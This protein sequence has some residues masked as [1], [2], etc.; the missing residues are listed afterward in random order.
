MSP[1]ALRQTLAALA[2]LGAFTS[3]A[4][5]AHAAPSAKLDPSLAAMLGTFEKA[6][7]AHNAPAM[8]A[9]WTPDAFYN[10]TVANVQVKGRDAIGAAYA[11]LFKQQ[12]T[13]SLKLTIT[14]SKIEGG[15]ASLLGMAEVTQQGQL[16]TRSLFRASLE[17]VGASWL[18]SSVEESE[19]PA[20]SPTGMSQFGW[21]AGTWTEALPSGDVK[22]TYHWVNG[23][24]F[25]VR[26]YSRAAK[27][28]PAAEG[29]QI[30]GWDAEQQCIRTWLFDSNG[31][32]GEGYW[33]RQGA[34]KWVNKMA[35]KLPD[36]RRGSVTQIMTRKGD[37]EIILQSVDREIDGQFQPNTAPA[38]MTR[39]TKGD[40]KGGQQ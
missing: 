11:D 1:S 25:M 38:T 13:S 15:K 31:S 30:F 9:L 33:Q 36:G 32:F 10:A 3:A 23:G 5:P 14:E 28:G 8:M 4:A 17:K 12:P 19:L 2:L 34:D 16:P 6:F 24:A 27:Q 39:Q 22:N 21:L 29:T 26:N 37:N 18:F 35:L 40:A 20:D 7:N